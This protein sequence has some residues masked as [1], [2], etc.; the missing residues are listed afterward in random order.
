MTFP[1]DEDIED[2]EDV[3]RTAEEIARR[4]LVLSAVITSAYGASTEQIMDW[5]CRE[6]L[7]E[8]LTAQEREFLCGRS[9]EQDRINFTWRVE[10]LQVLLWCINKIDTLS[11]ISAQCDT[12]VL[13]RAI[14]FPPNPTSD[15][16]SSASLRDESTVFDESERVYQAHWRVRDAE[17]HSRKIP[18]GIDPGVV[19]ERHYAFNWV[20]G[21]M[22][23]EWDDISTDT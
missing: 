9:T 2:I 1:D 15:F 23:Q 7:Q 13:K 3:P 19:Y 22:G 8:E 21:Y 10:A 11:P 18:K 20:S 6:R 5:L 14:V 17:L 12:E 4:V 16:I